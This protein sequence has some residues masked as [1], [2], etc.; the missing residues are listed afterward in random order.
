MNRLLDFLEP[1]VHEKQMVFLWL[2]KVS[3]EED[4]LLGKKSEFTPEEEEE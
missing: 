3:E 4:F 1:A 2:D